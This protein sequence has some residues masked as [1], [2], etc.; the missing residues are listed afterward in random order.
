MTGTSPTDL[1]TEAFPADVAPM[2]AT[3]GPLPGDVRCVISVLLALSSIN[4]DC[5][6]RPMVS[7]AATADIQSSQSRLEGGAK[8]RC[9][10]LRRLTIADVTMALPQPATVK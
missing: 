5:I 7:A 10:P 9:D 1:V 2:L 3:A 8:R 4:T 6:D